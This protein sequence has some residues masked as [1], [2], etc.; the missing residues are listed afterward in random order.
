M[1][2]WI[3]RWR[4]WAMHELW[5]FYRLGLQPQALRYSYE[6]GGLTVPDQPIPW[7]AEAVL[8]EAMLRLPSPTARRKSDYQ[9]RLPNREPQAAETLRRQEGED[10]YRLFFRTPPPAVTTT[11]ELLWRGRVLDRV[12]L[13]MLSRDEFLQNLR[14]H[15][16]T[17]F[18]RL[19]DETVAC[20]TFVSTQCKGLMA[21]GVLTSPTSLVPLLDL[22]LQVEFRSERGG[23][24]QQV[25]AL[26]TV[27]PRRF[28]RRTG[29]WSATWMLGDHHLANHR[30]RAI[31]PRHFQ[32][33]LRVSD[34]RFVAQSEKHG[35]SVSRQV[36]PLE[37][38]QRVGPCFLVCSRE[39]GMAGLCSLSIHAQVPGAI[40]PPPLWEREVLITDGPTMVV[41]GTMAAADLAQVNAFEL[42]LKGETLGI[43]SLCPAPTAS[44]TSEGS[45][46]SPPIDYTWSMAAEEEL[47]ERLSKLMDGPGKNE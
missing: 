9:L 1:W 33:S 44:F 19:G 14:L 41:P 26:V 7:N 21:T 45:F 15:M 8:V 46:K 24:V 20:Q 3:K 10:H 39:Q 43:L 11:A 12:T 29:A 47:S 31:S 27:V 42:S 22:D 32:R 35:V 18:V 13:P 23:A 38:V 28:P 2:P 25:P 4:D 37:S 16:P 6:K 36:P 34:T 30:I 5:P 17:L 40:H